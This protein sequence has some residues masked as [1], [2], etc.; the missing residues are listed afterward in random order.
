MTLIALVT[1]GY[2]FIGSSIVKQLHDTGK[3]K[4]IRILDDLSYG[5]LSNVSVPVVFHEGCITNPVIVREVM[6]DVTHIFHCAA[7]I[8][9]HESTLNPYFYEN[10]NVGGTIVLLEEAIRCGSIES[11]VFSSSCS[12]YGSGGH[13]SESSETKPLSPYAISKLHCESYLR[14][15]KETYGLNVCILRYFNVYGPKQ[16][17]NKSYASVIPSFIAKCMQN[18]PLTIYGSGTQ[19][20]DFVHVSDVARANIHVAMKG[21]SGVYNLGCGR[22]ASIETIAM[23]VIMYTH[24]QLSSEFIEYQEARNG[25]VS[26]ISCDNTKLLSTGFT[27]KY[28]LTKGIIDTI[29]QT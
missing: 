1:G 8:S 7:Q 25:D 11:F 9:T 16:D 24:H 29:K 10:I 15:Y 28:T 14:Y 20:R 2:G 19:T 12:V 4:E 17:P 3:F 6:E 22:S 5:K 21:L 18:S 23:I 13:V 26:H 27:F